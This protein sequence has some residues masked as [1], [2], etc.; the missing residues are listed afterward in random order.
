MRRLTL[1]E[2]RTEPQV[3]LSAEERDALL[4]SVPSITM[5]P[6]VGLEGHYDLTPSSYIGAVEVGSLSVTILPK[7]PV[8]RM[9]FLIS[10]ALDPANWSSN[11]FDFDE[12]DSLLEA[13]IPGFVRQL[14]TALR[15]GVL[16]ISS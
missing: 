12:E 16:L 14:Q 3:S 2:Y 13:I 9:M 1:H 5:T 15:R 4:R 10:Y 6:S 7:I 11:G 8:S